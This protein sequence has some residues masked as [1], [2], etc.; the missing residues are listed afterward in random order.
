MVLDGYKDLPG[1]PFADYFRDLSQYTNAQLYW[2]A[3][4]R[5]AIG[6]KETDWQPELRPVDLDDDMYTG[7]V[8]SL[9]NTAAAKVIWIQT[10]SLAG[11]V[12]MAL[13]EN[14][15]M[16]IGNVPE[17]LDPEDRA[18][19]AAGI[20]ETEIV[21]ETEAYYRPFSAWVESATRWQH[22]H[23]HPEHGEDVPV[24]RLI[25]TSEISEACEPLAIQALE[26]F[27]EKGPA[28]K[29]VNSVFVRSD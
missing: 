26:S 20:P 21:Q 29:R 9:V 7:H 27:L 23:D 19:I 22:D 6:F 12:N 13:R 1:F 16:D 25:L 14:G 17:E 2:L 4:L 18:G 24:E 15:P 10:L 28:M 11:E 8:I 3:V 5:H